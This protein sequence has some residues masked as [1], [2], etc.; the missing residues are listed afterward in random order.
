M[1]TLFVVVSRGATATSFCEEW[2]FFIIVFGGVVGVGHTEC[3]Q[4]NII[5]S[6]L[7]INSLLSPMLPQRSLYNVL[8]AWGNPSWE[9]WADRFELQ[10]LPKLMLTDSKCSDH[11]IECFK[12][13]FAAFV[14]HTCIIINN[15]FLFEH[16]T[17]YD[18][19]E[20]PVSNCYSSLH[21]KNS[22]KDLTILLLNDFFT[23]EYSR[24]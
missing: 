15:T 18:V 21:N 19:I 5:D 13:K 23:V 1:L 11:R 10:K 3:S 20:E 22:L 16:F 4:F 17:E 7:I 24:F 2:G 9:V 6:I 8:V 12:A 14:R